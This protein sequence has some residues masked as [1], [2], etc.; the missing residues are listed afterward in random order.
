VKS[1][2]WF[3]VGAVVAAVGLFALSRNPQGKALV[4]EIEAGADE[5][6]AA[7]KAEFDTGR[8]R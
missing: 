8:E 2:L 4:A 3:V 5:F 1:F 7:V 6:M